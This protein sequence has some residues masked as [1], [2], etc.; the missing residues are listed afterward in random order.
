MSRLIEETRR[1]LLY[2]LDGTLGTA[3]RRTLGNCGCRPVPVSSD[4]EQEKADIVFCGHS[5][6][7]LTAALARFGD[8]PVV[9]VS[10]L[11]E[12]EG[13]L[14]ALEAGAA[15][16]CTAPFEATQI[17]WLLETH[18]RVRHGVAAT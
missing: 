3:L 12:V 8:L 7:V 16:Y 11:P 18:T 17:R 1:A 13:W 10:R 15:D 5:R 4:W 2:G 14:D 6:E 9:V